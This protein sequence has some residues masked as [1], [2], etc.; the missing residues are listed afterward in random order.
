MAYSYISLISRQ[1]S[2]F[3]LE[4]LKVKVEGMEGTSK[5]QLLTSSSVLV[6]KRFFPHRRGWLDRNSIAE[7]LRSN[8]YYIVN[9]VPEIAGTI[10]PIF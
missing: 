4:A 7:F 10:F 6:E 9:S 1:E 5:D 8:L 3:T 2:H